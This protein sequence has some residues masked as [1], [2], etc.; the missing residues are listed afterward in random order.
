MEFRDDGINRIMQHFFSFP[1]DHLDLDKV[2]GGN[3]K[4]N[5]F[6][7]GVLEIPPLDVSILQISFN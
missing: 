1:E 4:L 2:T 7:G 3:T 6:K 5:N